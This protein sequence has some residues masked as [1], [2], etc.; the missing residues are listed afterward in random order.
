MS[1]KLSFIQGWRPKPRRFWLLVTIAFLI[2]IF[3]A[4]FWQSLLC[5]VSAGCG[6]GDPSCLSNCC[7]HG[8]ISGR[9]AYQIT[10]CRQTGPS[11]CSDTG[12]RFE[13]ECPVNGTACKF[14]Y[15]RGICTFQNTGTCHRETH[16]AQIS[17]CSSAPEPTKTK[18]PDPTNPP[19]PTATWTPVPTSTATPTPTPEPLMVDLQAD[20]SALLFMAPELGQPTQILR[21]SVSGGTPPYA[22]SVRV[23]KPSGTTVTYV[24]GNA[25][26]FVVNANNTGD[27]YFGVDEEGEWT[28]WAESVDSLGWNAVSVPVTWDVS[29]YPVHEE[30]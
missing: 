4:F 29:W 28:A 21:G 20:Y 30:P 22:V 24:L 14:I 12:T 27:P 18:K 13:Y 7:L 8:P 10:N 9:K 2:A 5:M 3:V 25:S 17:C 6:P 23:Q 15:D 1:L 16:N 19:P 26:T 11:I